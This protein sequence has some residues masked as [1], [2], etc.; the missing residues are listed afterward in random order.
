MGQGARFHSIHVSCVC[1]AAGTLG[2]PSMEKK[3][4]GP[5]CKSHFDTCILL[6]WITGTHIK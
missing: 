5:G 4:Y 2:H 6:P 1:S 3:Q